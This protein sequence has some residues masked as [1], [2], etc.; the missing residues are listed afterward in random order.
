MGE[1][2]RNRVRANYSGRNGNGKENSGAGTLVANT[3]M[4]EMKWIMGG[5]KGK[6]KPIH[7]RS[8]RIPVQAEVTESSE[9]RRK[10]AGSNPGKRV[11]SGGRGA[12]EPV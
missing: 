8:T 7:F 1:W 5:G 3:L 10:K 6:K 2:E 4:G 9:E 11:E 12:R